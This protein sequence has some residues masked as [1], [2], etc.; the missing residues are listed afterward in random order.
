MAGSKGLFL[1]H[2]QISLIVISSLFVTLRFSAR[3]FMTHNLSLDDAICFLAFPVA[4]ALAS[5]EIRA[6]G[7]GS[8]QHITDVPPEK[9][10][11]LFNHFPSIQ[12]LYIVAIG[13]VRGCIVAF[14]PRLWTQ[15]K[16][17]LPIWVLG[18]A[19]LAQTVICFFFLL[20]ECKH[21]PDL[22]NSTASG[23]QCRSRQYETHIFWGHAATGILIDTILFVL[24]LWIIYTQMTLSPYKKRVLLIFSVGLFVII[25]GPIRLGII[26]TTDFNIDTTIAL[27][28]LSVWTNLEVHVGL[29][30]ACFPTMQ[31]FVRIVTHRLGLSPTSQATSQSIY[32]TNR[33]PRLSTWKRKSQGYTEHR[34]ETGDEQGISNN[35]SGKSII[36]NKGPNCGLAMNN[37]SVTV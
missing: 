3:C 19:V 4:I 20:F 25:I 27:V 1:L 28:R 14:L 16:A 6:V 12:L 17:K 21:I 7:Y 26:I 2:F 31:P 22:W 8:G 13:L 35:S 32:R 9:L 23:R 15:R 29:W 10:E 36:R 37:F 33:T 18:F 34:T 30:V 11:Q 5:M 24:P